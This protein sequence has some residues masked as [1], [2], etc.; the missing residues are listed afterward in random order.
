MIRISVQVSSGAAR[1]RVAV[2]AESIERAPEERGEA[3]PR[4]SVPGN[5]SHRYRDLLRRGLRCLGQA[6][7]SVELAIGKGSP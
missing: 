6:A 7:S 5:V 1:F 3:I 2:Q 4:Q